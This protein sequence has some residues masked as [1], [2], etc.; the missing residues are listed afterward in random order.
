MLGQNVDELSFSLLTLIVKEVLSGIN[1]WYLSSSG[2]RLHL[3]LMSSK[4]LLKYTQVL[5]VLERHPS[6]QWVVIRGVLFTDIVSHQDHLHFMHVILLV[7][8]ESASVYDFLQSWF[9]W[10]GVVA[11]L[12]DVVVDWVRELMTLFEALMV[13]ANEHDTQVQLLETYVDM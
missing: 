11:I 13:G 2:H 10:A 8:L 7:H 12:H 5:H 4:H 9:L 6:Q 3:S 1:L